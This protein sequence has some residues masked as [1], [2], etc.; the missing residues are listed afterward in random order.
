RDNVEYGSSSPF[1]ARLLTGLISSAL[2]SLGTSDSPTSSDVEESITGPTLLAFSR[3]ALFGS[4]F[5]FVSCA[6]P[7]ASIST[8]TLPTK[9]PALSSLRFPVAFLAR[10]APNPF[11]LAILFGGRS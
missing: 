2:K 5:R 4:D 8:C 1:L 7:S 6:P 10:V 3:D 11:F 9:T